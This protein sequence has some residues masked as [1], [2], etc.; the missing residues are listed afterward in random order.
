M[1]RPAAGRR[2]ASMWRTTGEWFTAP[3]FVSA[4][5]TA[6]WLDQN[7]LFTT[8]HRCGNIVAVI[9]NKDQ[10]FDDTSHTS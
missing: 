9:F 5:S 7:S 2:A 1:T 4:S 10:D 8:A 6:R 3:K